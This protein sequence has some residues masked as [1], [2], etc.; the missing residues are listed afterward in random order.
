MASPIKKI[1]LTIAGG[2]TSII[3]AKY[4]ICMAKYLDSELF[5]QYVINMKALDDLLKAKVFVEVES[6]E[7]ER[8]LEEQG[9]RYL[10]NIKEL[11]EAK[12]VKVNSIL[13][14]GVIHDEVVKTLQES[15]MDI[16]IM[17]EL[18]ELISRTNSF[19]DEGERIFREAKCPVLVVKGE[20]ERIE[21]MYG[22]LPR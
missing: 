18:K 6:M 22:D 1:L 7:Y 11:A 20:E 16:L 15:G 4:A 2:D 10:N 3:A 17:G 9:T 5:V 13:S 21:R 12:G 8:E 19:Y 14:K